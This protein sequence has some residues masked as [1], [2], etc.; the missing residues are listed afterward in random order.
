M[1]AESSDR[2]AVAGYRRGL[3]RSVYAVEK[4]SSHLHIY[5][6]VPGGDARCSGLDSRARA[7]GMGRTGNVRHCLLLAVPALLLHRMAVP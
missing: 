6:S 5:W 3:S 7:I 1:D 4:S 2:M